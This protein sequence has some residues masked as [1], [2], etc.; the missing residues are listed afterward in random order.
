MAFKVIISKEYKEHP[1][2]YR[3]KRVRL[4]AFFFGEIREYKTK[5][6]GRQLR[7]YWSA[8]LAGEQNSSEKAWAFDRSVMQKMSSEGACLT[9]I[10]VMVTSD[11]KRKISD[12][13]LISSVWL[14]TASRMREFGHNN[15]LAFEYFKV[16]EREVSDDVKLKAMKVGGRK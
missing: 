9:H 16:T 14:T 4:G 15:C 11:S 7:I 3:V 12:P 6:N 1:A 10:G 13:S 2:G 8:R 5:V